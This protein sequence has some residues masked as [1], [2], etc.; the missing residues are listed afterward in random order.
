MKSTYLFFFSPGKILPFMY[1]LSEVNGV[2]GD[3]DLTDEVVLSKAVKIKHL[4]HQSLTSQL[5]VRD[6]QVS[7]RPKHNFNLVPEVWRYLVSYIV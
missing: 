6:L 4:Q 1:R 7:N 2:H 5:A 3:F